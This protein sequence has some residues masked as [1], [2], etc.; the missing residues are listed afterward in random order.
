[1]PVSSL[2]SG[3]KT[4][5][6]LAR[7]AL[8]FPLQ[9]RMELNRNKI[10]NAKVTDRQFAYETKREIQ[11]KMCK[12]KHKSFEIFN[13]LKRSSLLSERAQIYSKVASESTEYAYATP[14]IQRA[15]EEV[16]SRIMKQLQASL[17][18]GGELTGGVNLNKEFNEAA[19]AELG[20]TV[21]QEKIVKA[22][23]KGK[24]PGTSK[25]IAPPPRRASNH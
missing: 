8:T 1:M 12:Y 23:E 7:L 17:K 4:L 24:P 9:S 2:P 3:N 15:N 22:V 14:T 21:N 19:A 10:D 16:N 6:E 13:S 20:R 5:D 18:K 25:L 11:L